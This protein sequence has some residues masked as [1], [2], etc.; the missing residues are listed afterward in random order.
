MM[1]SIRRNIRRREAPMSRFTEWVLEKSAIGLREDRE[2][3]AF[4]RVFTGDYTGAA[5]IC[6]EWTP[7][8]RVRKWDLGIPAGQYDWSR[9]NPRH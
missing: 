3:P 4:Q 9:P 8:S 2:R 1:R 5:A 7:D 6:G